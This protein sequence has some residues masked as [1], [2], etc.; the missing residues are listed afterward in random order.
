MVR[1]PGHHAESNGPQG[2]CLFNNVMVGAAHAQ[3]VHGVGRVA[4][5]DF[6]VHHGNGGEDI[7]WKDIDTL[8]VSS[9]QTPLFPGTGEERGRT[10]GF[11]NVVSAPLPAD[12]GSRQF[13]DAWRNLLLP[14]VKAFEPEVIFVSAGFDAHVND[15]LAQVRLTDDDFAWITK[16]VSSLAADRPVI[17]VLEG[18]YNVAQLEKSVRAHLKALMGS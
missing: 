3:R 5:L 4:V 9:H 11:G 10:G 17:S 2:F 16:E 15:P 18:G 12:A 1:P 7:A 6:D 14:A 8:Y 13:R